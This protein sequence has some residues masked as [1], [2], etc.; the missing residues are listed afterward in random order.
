MDNNISHDSRAIANIF[1]QMAQ[2]QGETLLTMM[3]LLKYIYFAHGWTLGYLNHPLICHNV[4]A[5]KY[6]PVVPEIY[7]SYIGGTFL[8]RGRF[9]N[10]PNKKPYLTELYSNEKIIIRNVYRDYS[11]LN[12][13]NCLVSLTVQT[14]RGASTTASFMKLFLMRKFKHITK[15]LSP[16]IKIHPL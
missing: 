11:K 5:W 3:K 13:F 14:R 4:E 1:V 2:E 9:I 10:K 16:K 6:G 7:H 15:T 8:I 12:L